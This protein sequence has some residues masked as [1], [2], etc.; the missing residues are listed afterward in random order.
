MKSEHGKKK[1]TMNNTP[2]SFP[3][4]TLRASLHPTTYFSTYLHFFAPSVR[5]VLQSAGVDWRGR[6]RLDVAALA[7]RRGRPRQTLPCSPTDVDNKLRK[8]QVLAVMPYD[9]SF[10]D[11]FELLLLYC[12]SNTVALLYL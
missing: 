6:S 3:S 8:T 10:S 5:S 2:V 4:V 12:Y 1:G 11:F 7:S 9:C